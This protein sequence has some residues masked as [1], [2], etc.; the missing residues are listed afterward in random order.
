[1]IK[2][3][4][5]DGR[6]GA[7]IKGNSKQFNN[8][9]DYL[10]NYTNATYNPDSN[11]W[12]L[13]RDLDIIEKIQKK[14]YTASDVNIYKLADIEQPHFKTSAEIFDEEKSK[15][16]EELTEY[17]DLESLGFTLKD[18]QLIGVLTA[19]YRLYLDGGFLIGDSMG[20]GKTIE[21]MAIIH[22]LRYNDLLDKTIVICPK[23]VK[24]QWHRELEKFSDMSSTVVDSYNKE[25]RLEKF[26]E[27]S[28]IYIV[29]PSQLI[30]DEDFSRL[31]EIDSDLVVVD[32][33]HFF[34]NRD[35]QR[36]QQLRKLVNDKQFV[37]GLTGTP[38]QNKPQEAYSI[39]EFLVPDLFDTLSKFEK[40][41]ITYNYQYGYPKYEGG[42]NLFDLSKRLGPYT[43]RRRTEDVSDELPDLYKK[44]RHVECDSLQS[45]LHDEVEEKIMDVMNELDERMQEDDN[46]DEEE[47]ED[48]DGRILGLK[49]IQQSIADD[50]RVLLESDSPWVRDLVEDEDISPEE[51]MSPKFSS[52]L[53]LVE[54]ILEADDDYK[55]ITFSQFARVVLMLDDYFD[56]NVILYG[57]MDEKQRDEAV[58]KF[59]E[60]D[61]CRLF[62]ASDAGCTGYNL[63]RA[64]HLINFDIPWNPATL[65]QRIGRIRRI[66][67]PWQ[68]VF[69]TNYLTDHTIDMQIKKSI[70]KKEAIFDSVVENTEKQTQ[71][72]EEITKKVS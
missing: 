2:F 6:L 67:S 54:K 24:Y 57:A 10:K 5:K 49:N 44:E 64:S 35:T 13:P 3:V 26:E 12:I 4:V 66:G 36:S 55:I 62:I 61:S 65:K 45:R 21:A 20:L 16:I 33:I 58:E 22:G 8:A 47:I 9:L 34:K 11:L 15:S 18:F 46:L 42:R 68:E 25:K 30:I 69:I 51:Y 19:L 52:Y 38:L 40:K 37:L 41:Y 27:D 1:M 60:D 71:I 53:K 23:N 56:N 28:D 59:T 39:F 14:F 63:Q 43:I 70:E 7:K 17:F 50:P 48:Y 32:E 29:N 72:I 31:Q